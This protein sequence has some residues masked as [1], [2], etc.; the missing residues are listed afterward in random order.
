MSA[1]ANPFALLAERVER[2]RTEK[3]LSQSELVDRM[4][5]TRF[6]PKVKAATHIS[7]IEG[8][9][10]EKLPSV[11]VLAALAEVLD[12]SMDYL[13][14]L[15][16]NPAP[17]RVGEHQVAINAADKEER[18]LLQELFELIHAHS[19]DEQRFIAD[20][21]RRLAAGA[22]PRQGRAPIVICKEERTKR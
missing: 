15:S 9:E 20:V 6:R 3:R 14:G 22:T 7:N 16:D 13:A 4:R 12:T 19:L 10:G 11:P 18:K 5:S 2:R 1:D 21:V 8:A 17:A